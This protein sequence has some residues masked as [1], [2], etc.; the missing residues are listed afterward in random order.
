MDDQ[1]R[2]M[3]IED[4]DV[5]FKMEIVDTQRESM[6]IHKDGANSLEKDVGFPDLTKKVRSKEILLLHRA[7]CLL[8]RK[9]QCCC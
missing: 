5:D 6:D 4:K 3:D 9:R 2:E 7:K 1:K 8:L